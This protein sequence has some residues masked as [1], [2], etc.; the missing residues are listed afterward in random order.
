MRL[1]V[2]LSANRVI[3]N[4]KFSPADITILKDDPGL[5]DLLQ[6]T[7]VNMVRPSSSLF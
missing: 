5:P 3:D 6:P 2:I 7:C 1:R 4:Y